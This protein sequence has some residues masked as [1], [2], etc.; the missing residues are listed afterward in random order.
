MTKK[1]RTIYLVLGIVIG[2]FLTACAGVVTGKINIPD[3]NAFTFSPSVQ[4]VQAPEFQLDTVNL[5]PVS[6]EKAQLMT[7]HRAISLQETL[8]Q[9]ALHSG[10]CD[11]P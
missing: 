8:V 1:A 7:S 4:V 10:L 6:Y 11:R 2:L 9:T 5:V 3:H